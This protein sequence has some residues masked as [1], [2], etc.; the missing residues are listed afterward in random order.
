MS[1]DIDVLTLAGLAWAYF[2]PRRRCLLSEMAEWRPE[3]EPRVLT[4][5]FTWQDLEDPT[6][7]T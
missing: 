2:Y 6:Q 3:P 4:R 5:A 1:F 7:V